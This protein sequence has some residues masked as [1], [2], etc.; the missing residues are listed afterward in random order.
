MTG[1]YPSL[2]SIIRI[3]APSPLNIDVPNVVDLEGREK[4]FQVR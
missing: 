3:N 1:L 2:T 4:V